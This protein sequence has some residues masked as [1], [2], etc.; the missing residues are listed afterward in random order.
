MHTPDHVTSF[1]DLE[2]A[3]LG[4]VADAWRAR[5]GAARA[6]GFAYVQ[7]LLNEG[8]EAGASRSHSHS[9]LAWLREQPPVPA[10]EQTSEPCALCELISTELAGG[11]R[12]VAAQDGLVLLCPPAG[13]APYELLV[14]P[15]AHEEDAFASDVLEPA[16]GLLAE[17]MRRVFG[18]AARCPLNAWLHTSAFGG[19]GHWHLELVPR[20]TVFAGL[21]LGAGIYVN[22][23]P[24]EAAAEALRGAAV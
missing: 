7:A 15:E 1:A 3:Q 20:L 8:P 24:P 4:L 5:A 12:V 11:G 2:Q 17:G 16:L 6:E 22:A 9:Q 10:L 14:A 21:E 18:A 19:P 23:L 13:R